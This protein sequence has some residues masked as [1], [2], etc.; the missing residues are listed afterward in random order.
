MSYLEL[1]AV[2]IVEFGVLQ[3]LREKRDREDVKKRVKTIYKTMGKIDA[4]SGSSCSFI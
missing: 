3:T 4:P 2:C 1:I